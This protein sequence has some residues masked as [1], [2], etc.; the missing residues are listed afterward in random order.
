MPSAN[1]AVNVD[2]KGT[3]GGNSHSVDIIS[4]TTSSVRIALNTDA[5]NS[6]PSFDSTNISVTVVI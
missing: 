1:F 4:K 6:Y 2:Y 5:A 3:G